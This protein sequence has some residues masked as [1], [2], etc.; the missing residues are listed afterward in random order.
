[1]YL[2]L[3]ACLMNNFVNMD[4]IYFMQNQKNERR[5]SQQQ[6]EHLF[7]HIIYLYHFQWKLFQEHNFGSVYFSCLNALSF[8]FCEI[9]IQNNNNAVQVIREFITFMISNKCNIIK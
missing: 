7:S 2:L 5:Q 3:Y 8:I 6:Q 4:S 1:M 9:Q